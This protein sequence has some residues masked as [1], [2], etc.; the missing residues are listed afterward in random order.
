LADSAR[1]RRESM[2]VPSR[3]KTI[4]RNRRFEEFRISGFEDWEISGFED[5]KIFDWL[6]FHLETQFS[7]ASNSENRKSSNPEILKS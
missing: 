2:S 4:R 6:T 1:S 3:S 5:L 7:N